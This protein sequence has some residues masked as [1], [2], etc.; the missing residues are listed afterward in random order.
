M[1]KRYF[2]IVIAC[3]LGCLQFS[4]GEKYSQKGIILLTKEEGNSFLM[5]STTAI[6]AYKI[7]DS[8]FIE[9]CDLGRYE[10]APFS[11]D[12]VVLNF[13]DLEKPYEYS[14]EGIKYNTEHNSKPY[15]YSWL[16]ANQFNRALFHN[17]ILVI[18]KFSNVK[19]LKVMDFYSYTLDDDLIYVHP[20]FFP[21]ETMTS[22]SGEL[23]ATELREDTYGDIYKIIQ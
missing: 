5:E 20:L 10:R 1:E 15:M 13:K 8:V 2:Q 17:G 4:C 7:E 14:I 23:G 18:G 6:I 16:N 22:F 3:F 9:N 11:G 21:N 12:S 19:E